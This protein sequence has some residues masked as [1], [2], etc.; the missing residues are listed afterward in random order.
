MS[1]F[2]ALGGPAVLRNMMKRAC[3]AMSL[4]QFGTASRRPREIG[5]RNYWIVGT[6]SGSQ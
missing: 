6:S 4:K 2:R 3:Q 5:I 1:T